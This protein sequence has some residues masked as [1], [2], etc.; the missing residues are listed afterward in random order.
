MAANIAL[1]VTTSAFGIQEGHVYADATHE[2]FPG[3]PVPVNGYLY[4]SNAPGWGVDLDEAEAA[5][6]PP[7]TG[8]HER[9]AARVRRPDSSRRESRGAQSAV[10]PAMLTIQPMPNLSISM[11]NSSPHICFSS[12]TVMVAPSDSFSQ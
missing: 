6:Y 11:P 3:T 1:D 12:G 8:L 10:A 4:P 9:W 7:E 5:K 2:V